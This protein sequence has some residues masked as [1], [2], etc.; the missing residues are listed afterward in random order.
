MSAKDLFHDLVKTALQ[1]EGWQITHDPY[2]IELEFTDLLIDLGAEQI[3]GATRGNQTIAV[4]IKSFLA[5]SAI[6]DFH[7]AIGQFINY[8][9]ALED[10]EPERKLY[11][12]VPAPIHQRF[13]GYAFIQKVITRNQVP[14]IIYNNLKPEIS[15]W[16]D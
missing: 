14:L 9:L 3:L 13:F 4:E 12:A 16:I 6:T 8:K 15:Q 1:N 11:L 7:V 5:N 2:R 10:I